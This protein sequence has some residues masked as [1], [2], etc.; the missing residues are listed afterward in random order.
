ME[1]MK[2]QITDCLKNTIGKYYAFE[3]DEMED[4]VEKCILYSKII[5]KKKTQK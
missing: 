3:Q 4:V 2:Q 1:A 5:N